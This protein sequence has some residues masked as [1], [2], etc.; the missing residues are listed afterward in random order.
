MRIV[1]MRMFAAVDM[2]FSEKKKTETRKKDEE[3]HWNIIVAILM[4]ASGQAIR[5]TS[6]FASLS[7]SYEFRIV[8]A[9]LHGCGVYGAYSIRTNEWL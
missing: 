5:L 6:F 8:R 7:S 9:Q 1:M 3:V 2:G 4:V